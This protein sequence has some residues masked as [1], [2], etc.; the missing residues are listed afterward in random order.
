[1]TSI[2]PHTQQTRLSKISK[3]FSKDFDQ[4]WWF[5]VG[6]GGTV[7]LKICEVF[8]LRQNLKNQ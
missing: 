1:M 5:Y 6:A 3:L 8:F 2:Q 7:A 4:Q